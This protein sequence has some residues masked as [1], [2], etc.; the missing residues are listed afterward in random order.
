RGPR[1][2]R[3]VT[4]LPSIT[5]H[6]GQV[7]VLNENVYTLLSS[8]PEAARRDAD[9]IAE[10]LSD[11]HGGVL[12]IDIDGIE[13]AEPN[14]AVIQEL[15]DVASLWIDG[16]I[17]TEE[18]AT[19]LIVAGAD[20]V[21]VSTRALEGTTLGTGLLP[22]VAELAENTVLGI[23]WQGGVRA[24]GGVVGWPDVGSPARAAREMGVTKAI[25]FDFDRART[26]G[27]MNFTAVRELVEAGLS[28]YVA[29][30]TKPEDV[31]AVGRLG[32]TGLVLDVLEVLR[33]EAKENE[34]KDAPRA[35]DTRENRRLAKDVV[36]RPSP[37]RSSAPNPWE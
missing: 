18:E 37:M 16:G 2:V 12:A 25:L 27:T 22:R 35:N 4:L 32:A 3:T 17:V 1:V 6:A 8:H 31:D 11:K 9:E 28:T 7:T 29:G 34:G 10:H 14:Y 30:G 26:G 36:R 15:G 23:H 13:R 24:S 33:M 5:L 19:D 21:V 20:H